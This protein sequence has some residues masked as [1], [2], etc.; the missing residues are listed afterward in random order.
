MKTSFKHEGLEND[1]LMAYS[2]RTGNAARNAKWHNDKA[3]RAKIN[4]KNDLAIKH[5]KISENHKKAYN[6]LSKERAEKGK[7][8]INELRSAEKEGYSVTPN[9]LHLK[10]QKGIV[11]NTNKLRKHFKE[12]F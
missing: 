8:L 3:N 9:G 11:E 7:E 12:S 2:I 5:K 6:T 4:G 10:S 1:D